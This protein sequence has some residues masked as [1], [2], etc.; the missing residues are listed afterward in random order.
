LPSS[1]PTTLTHVWRSNV[2]CFRFCREL[3]PPLL[4]FAIHF[5]NLRG[6]GYSRHPR[7]FRSLGLAE[8]RYRETPTGRPNTQR[9]SASG[10]GLGPVNFIQIPF[11]NER[12]LDLIEVPASGGPR[13]QLAVDRKKAG[14]R[15]P[16]AARVSPRILAI[17]KME[18]LYL[19]PRYSSVHPNKIG[20]N[21]NDQF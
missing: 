13:L 4:D 20:I 2:R 21:Q 6:T 19:A 5:C 1:C 8:I 3:E 12:M 7:T 17:Y 15:L 10:T 14:V 11:A 16:R 9:T 18:R